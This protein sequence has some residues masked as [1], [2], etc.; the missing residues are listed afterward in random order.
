[1]PGQDRRAA[2]AAYK[3]KK[4]R[5]G[6]YALRCA[7]SG[8]VWVGRTLTLETV[9]NRHWFA[10]RLGTASQASLQAAWTAHGP[11]SFRFEVLE[12]LPEEEMAYLRDALLKDRLAHWRAALGAELL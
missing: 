6:I 3:E 10:L 2:I 1:M 7:A 4:S 12:E 9:R 5:A 11:D 8:A